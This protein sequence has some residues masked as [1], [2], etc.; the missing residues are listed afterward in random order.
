[1]GNLDTSDLHR[2][3]DW[4]KL[5]MHD[6]NSFK[7]LSDKSELQMIYQTKL[8]DSLDTEKLKHFLLK[9]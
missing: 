2:F 1:M 4:E 9:C 7:S 6:L 3:H 8:T 5:Y